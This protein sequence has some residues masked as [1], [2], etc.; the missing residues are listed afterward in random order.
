MAEFSTNWAGAHGAC[1]LRMSGGG[2]LAKGADVLRALRVYM[3]QGLTLE[4]SYGSR[5]G[6]GFGSIGDS[7]GVVVGS[8]L[9]NHLQ[10]S[11]EHN[12]SSAHSRST[13]SAN[14]SPASLSWS[15]I[16]TISLSRGKGRCMSRALWEGISSSGHLG[17]RVDESIGGGE[18]VG[19]GGVPLRLR[20]MEVARSKQECPFADCCRT[21]SATWSPP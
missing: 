10:P 6:W 14:P 11:R 20:G 15:N 1:T 21:S 19:G 9:H 17:S 13:S 3:F 12:I 16:M 2:L 18:R 8:I 7:N 4:A 5:S